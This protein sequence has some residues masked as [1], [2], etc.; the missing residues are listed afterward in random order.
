MKKL[1]RIALIS[2]LGCVLVA[3]AWSGFSWQRIQADTQTISKKDY[4]TKRVD[5]SAAGIQR[6]ATDLDDVS[7][8]L[9]T[10]A[11]DRITV[12]YF[13]TKANK[14]SVVDA[15]GAVRISQQEGESGQ[16]YCLFRC[17]GT[18][19]TI[20]VTVPAKSA[21]AYDL[22]AGNGHV[23]FKQDALL[24]TQSLRIV[25]S[26]SNVE[27]Q[28]I[29]ANGAV[30]LQSDNGN[31][32]LSTVEVDGELRLRSSNGRHELADVKATAIDSRS[33]NGNT[34]FD[35]VTTG[36]LTAHNSNGRITLVELD[37]LRSTF[38]SDNGG[39][40]G[41]LAGAKELYDIKAR[42]SNGSLRING[43]THDGAY[44]SDAANSPRKVTITSSNATVDVTFSN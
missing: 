18:P 2:G 31:I 36:T 35:R 22:S 15:D 11:S 17:I 1:S 16:F 19:S 4:V 24:Q 8:E 44:F 5:V 14:F 27:L 42:S 6:I 33:D 40:E 26:N 43:E 25:S 37:A 38:T 9:Q 32:R 34:E 20:T 21:Y 7:V 23:R 29:K 10:H 13:E 28:D 39:V 3:F 30:R 12:E 41:S